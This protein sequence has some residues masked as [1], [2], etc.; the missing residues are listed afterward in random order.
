M[1]AGGGGWGSSGSDKVLEARDTSYP[2]SGDALELASM[3]RGMQDLSST[4]RALW[5]LMWLLAVLG[6]THSR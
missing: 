2:F 1:E 6:K 5:E 4:G 3:Q